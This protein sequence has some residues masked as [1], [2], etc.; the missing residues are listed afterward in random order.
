MGAFLS[1]SLSASAADIVGGPGLKDGLDWAPALWAG[2][3]V[4]VHGGGAWGNTDATDTFTYHGDPTVA[5]SNSGTS[6][7]GGGQTGYNFQRGSFVFGPE[8]DLGYLGLPGS[9]TVLLQNL[10]SDQY[11]LNAKYTASGGLYGDLTGRL[12]YTANNTLIY[13]KGGAAFL[14]ADLKAK[15]TGGNCTTG[16]QVGTCRG[17]P[18]VPSTFNYDT[19]DTLWGWTVGG[20][21]E[22][23]LSPSWSLKAEFLHFDFGTMSYTHNGTYDIPSTPWKSTLTGSTQVSTTVDTVKF[24]VNYHFTSDIAPWKE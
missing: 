1:F 16:V 8:A 12:G 9:K 10:P 17:L 6:F 15:Y 7:I 24:G 21:V 2:P 18:A 5:S 11:W 3:Y 19:S 13:A 23:A 14:N 22:Y 4:G 20:G